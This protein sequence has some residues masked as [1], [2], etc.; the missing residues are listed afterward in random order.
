MVFTKKTLTTPISRWAR[1]SA[2]PKTSCFSPS[3]EPPDETHG[4]S[5]AAQRLAVPSYTGSTGRPF[6]DVI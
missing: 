3:V 4:A 2:G 1:D 5:C 6:R